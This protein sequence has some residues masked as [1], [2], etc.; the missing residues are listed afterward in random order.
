ML[1]GTSRSTAKA[2]QPAAATRA[3]APGPATRTRA[4]PSR[5]APSPTGGTNV[6]GPANFTI[7][8]GGKLSPPAITSP[9]FVAIELTFASGDGRG[10]RVVVRTPAPQTLLVPAGGRKSV[11]IAGLRQ[12]SYPI[13]IDGAVKG[14]LISGG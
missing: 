14:S 11:K 8:A 7:S 10:H 6:R 4:A 5:P 12:G 13:A 1:L 3:S 2:R 9:A